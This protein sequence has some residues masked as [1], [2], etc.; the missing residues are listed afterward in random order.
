MTPRA[1][2][3]VKRELVQTMVENLASGKYFLPSFQRQFVWDED[4]IKDL[5][6]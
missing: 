5:I 6:D 4:D 3:D 1:K 2:I